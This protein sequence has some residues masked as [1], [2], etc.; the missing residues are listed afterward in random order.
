MTQA[1]TVEEKDM[2]NQIRSLLKKE[3]GQ[4]LTEY[5]LIISLV[6]VAVVVTLTALSGGITGTLT[7]VIGS[8]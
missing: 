3:E 5:A 1:Q 6:A 8:L 2:W 7:T 4:G